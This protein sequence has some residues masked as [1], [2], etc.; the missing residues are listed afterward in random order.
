MTGLQRLSRRGPVLALL[1]MGA[2]LGF[3]ASAQ[4]WWRASGD[5]A[6]VT[7]SGADATGGLSQAL[8]AVVLAGVLLALV[9]GV[10]GR[11][12]L[13]VLLAAAGTGMI[14]AGGWLT[15]PDPSSVRDKVRLLSLTDQFALK[16]TVWP[17]IYCG[18]GLL[19]LFAAVLLWLGAPKWSARSGRFDRAEAPGAALTDADQGLLT[20]RQLD[21]GVDPTDTP[22]SKPGDTTG[23]PDV[24]PDPEQVR[25]DPTNHPR[26]E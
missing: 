23:D 25:M 24:Q 10:R 8:A 1:L 4:P 3:V 12:V 5:A 9:L 19:V 16:F 13:A 15:E 2:G 20:W 22:E 17:W 11:R 21:A 14:V 6:A 7:F 18:A 26:R